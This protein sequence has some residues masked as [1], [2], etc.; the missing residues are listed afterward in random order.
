MAARSGG[1][2]MSGG[3]L[4]LHYSGILYNSIKKKDLDISLLITG[5]KDFIFL[6][7]FSI[8]LFGI[9]SSMLAMHKYDEDLE[10]FAKFESY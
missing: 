2:G 7:L 1:M 9:S 8:L 5:E 3:D 6:F 10:H 4:T